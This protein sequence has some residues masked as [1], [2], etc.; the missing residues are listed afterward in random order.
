MAQQFINSLYNNPNGLPNYAY[1]GYPQTLSRFQAPLGFGGYNLPPYINAQENI[2]RFNPLTNSQPYISPNDPINKVKPIAGYGSTTYQPITG[3]PTGSIKGYGTIKGS[4]PIMANSTVTPETTT[5]PVTDPK[6]ALFKSGKIAKGVGIGNSVLGFAP[7]VMNWNNDGSDWGSRAL[8]FTGGVG[9]V[10]SNLLGLISGHPVYGTMGGAGLLAYNTAN[11]DNRRRANSY[12]NLDINDP[13]WNTIALESMNDETKKILEAN[14]ELKA[15]LISGQLKS[16]N[17]NNRN[18]K[19]SLNNPQPT[20]EIAGD[21]LP[22]YD[23]Q[24]AP[25]VSNGQD[26]S[27]KYIKEQQAKIKEVNDKYTDLANKTVKNDNANQELAEELLNKP[28]DWTKG[29]TPADY[30][31]LQT[32]ENLRRTQN[33]NRYADW[34]DDPLIRANVA[35]GFGLDA[36][37]VW[38]KDVGEEGRIKNQAAYAKAMYDVQKKAEENAR[39]LQ[40]VSNMVRYGY[41]YIDPSLIGDATTKAQYISNLV[42]PYGRENLDARDDYRKAEIANNAQGIK[43]MSALGRSALSGEYGLANTNLRGYY[44]TSNKNADRQMEWDMEAG[45]QRLREIEIASK[46]GRINLTPQERAVIEGV[47]SGLIDINDA[48]TILDKY[49]SSNDVGIT[50]SG[51]QYTGNA[52]GNKKVLLTPLNINA[53]PN[54]P[55]SAPPRAARYYK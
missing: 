11:A 30:Q 46:T 44:T 17:E 3:G 55:L 7:M 39:F 5:A 33:E 2:S 41:P 25:V 20:S 31:Y 24:V 22:S 15:A 37:D 18:Y 12:A 52:G 28:I 34:V 8:D 23:V 13:L 16:I 27:E 49:S 36:N 14:P 6:A 32:M 29:Y 50:Q 9:N 19:N 54:I 48:L 10:S 35:K 51:P 26:K 38:G 40:G 4:A 47:K 53:G 42:G 45:R 1:R 21:T 43:D